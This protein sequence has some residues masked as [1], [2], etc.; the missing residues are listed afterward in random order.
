MQIILIG[1]GNTAAILG[2]LCLKAGHQVAQIFGRN[3]ETAGKLAEEFGTKAVQ[4]WQEIHH[5]ADIY[6]VAL[7]D[8][9]LPELHR[10][11][12]LPEGVVV[13]TAGSV[14]LSV[15]KG[16][17]KNYGV[18]YPL[19][20]LKSGEALPAAI[21]FLID[22][23]SYASKAMVMNFASTLSPLVTHAGDEER[24]Y[25][26]LSAVWVNNFANFLFTVA[27][28]ICREKGI[29]V[30]VLLPLLEHTVSRLRNYPPA[31]VQ[32]GPALR[33]DFLTM[34]KHLELLSD[35][36]TYAGLYRMLSEAISQYHHPL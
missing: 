29:D 27:W 18:L 36:P 10:Y 34:E 3:V 25:L 35:R 11:L 21:P 32:T 16:V 14:P 31:S 7:P 13:H 28:D 30:K 9:F 8:S 33:G 26:H 19:Q 2:R 4:S 5:H 1:S 12:W 24:L 6:I 17:S 22:G 15:L 20:S 23:S